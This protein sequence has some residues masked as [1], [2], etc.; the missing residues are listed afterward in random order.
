MIAVGGRRFA[1]IPNGAVVAL[2]A[3]SLPVVAVAAAARP[4]QAATGRVYSGGV[5]YECEGTARSG[6][7]FPSVPSG[8]VAVDC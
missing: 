8:C 1:T 2:L 7:A 5:H 3:V 6:W 4:A